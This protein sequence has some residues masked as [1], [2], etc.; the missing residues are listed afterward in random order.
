MEELVAQLVTELKLESSQFRTDMMQAQRFAAG[1]VERLSET[2]SARITTAFMRTSIVGKHAFNAIALTA[3]KA[4]RSIGSQISRLAKQLTL[5]GTGFVIAAPIALTYWLTR[6]ASEIDDFADEIERFKLPSDEVQQFAYAV[7]GL[8]VS[9]KE[10]IHFFADSTRRITE[11]S[12]G[13]G[14]I[15]K[16]F[17]RLGIDAKEFAGL[18]A[19]AGIQKL[20]DLTKHLNAQERITVFEAYS[21]GL[22]KILPLFEQGSE[23]INKLNED[24]KALGLRLSAEQLAGAGEFADQIDRLSAIWDIFKKQIAANLAGPLADVVDNMISSIKDAGGIREAANQ[25]AQ[26]LLDGIIYF[27]E[28]VKKLLEAIK[29]LAQL[30]KD[31]FNNLQQF[32]E[33]TQKQGAFSTAIETGDKLLSSVVGETVTKAPA[34]TFDFIFKNL[35]KNLGLVN[36]RSEDFISERQ[37]TI[38]NTT[39]EINNINN[40]NTNDNNNTTEK[41]TNVDNVTNN[42]NNNLNTKISNLNTNIDNN[43]NNIKQ[44]QTEQTKYFKELNNK[45]KI[46]NT[47]T[48]IKN[49]TQQYTREFNTQQTEFVN[50]LKEL[51]NE[52]KTNTN[53]QNVIKDV[54]TQQQQQAESV[55]MLDKTINALKSFKQQLE[56]SKILAPLNTAVFLSSKA[57]DKFTKDLELNTT[58]TSESLVSFKK[59]LDNLSKSAEQTTGTLSKEI[60]EKE[61][62]K[63]EEINELIQKN[64]VKSKPRL[65]SEEFNQTYQDTLQLLAKKPE[66]FEAAVRQNARQLENIIKFDT[67]QSNNRGEIVEFSTVHL[68]KRLKKLKTLFPA[69]LQTQSNTNNNNEFIRNLSSLNNNTNKTNYFDNKSLGFDES[70]NKITNSNNIINDIQNISN[71]NEIKKEI[72]NI[73][74]NVVKNI[75]DTVKN[76]FNTQNTVNSTIQNTKNST[77]SINEF[78]NLF[79]D[80]QQNINDMYSTV[81]N[82]SNTAAKELLHYQ[83]QSAQQ[84]IKLDVNVSAS[85][86]FDVKVEQTATRAAK[87]LAAK[88][89]RGVNR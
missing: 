43:I 78:H 44:F 20:F 12:H 41:Q 2:I 7:K 81:S 83:N 87:D 3:T 46:D 25:I 48:N 8:G 13:Y 18:D 19:T 63:Q 29:T 84:T 64:T 6:T 52:I 42:N 89:A 68:E 40:N 60:V 27:I 34:R 28:G 30:I 23:K 76:L 69:S 32:R 15:S 71:S 86:L 80:S 65:L 11:L 37:Q 21:S 58:K 9:G 47:S 59:A 85:P 50:N 54:P 57:F 39:N 49:N 77:N 35:T 45:Q 4:L 31:A 10:A 67:L 62:Q 55:G 70:G 26:A 38:I 72:N 24:F 16:L 22:S 33:K 56:D 82:V 14:R 66:G 88:E 1:S 17:Q 79:N 75:L 51:N 74:N 36:P 53:I 61:Q 73:T 5:L